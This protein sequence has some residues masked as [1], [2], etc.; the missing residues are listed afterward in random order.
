[1]GPNATSIYRVQVRF[2][3]TDL[4]GVVHHANYFV[5]CEAARV[6]WLHR[7]GVSYDSWVRHG[8]HLPVVEAKARFKAAARFDEILELTTSVVELTRVTVRYRYVM[9]RGAALVCEA[10]TLL[11]CVG[12]DLKLQRL[13]AEVTRVFKSPELPPSEWAPRG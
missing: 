13:P 2:C 1:V 9:R 7:R 8:I 5:Y 3:E 10:E 6:D 12:A 11:A 4:M